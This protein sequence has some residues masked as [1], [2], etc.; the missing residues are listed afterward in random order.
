MIVVLFFLNIS[1]MD[2]LTVVAV[3]FL[4]LFCLYLYFENKKLNSIIKELRNEDKK[5]YSKNIIKEDIVKM[6]DISNNIVEEKMV[7]VCDN[8]INNGVKEDNNVI[9]VKKEKSILKDSDKEVRFDIKDYVRKDKVVNR[10]LDSSDMN[11]E[12]LQEVSRELKSNMAPQT[13]KLTDYEQEQEDNAIISYKELL[14]VNKNNNV[15]EDGTLE[16]IE[17]L[18]KFRNNLRR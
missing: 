13:I 15:V 17:E 16:F 12:Y 5:N 6:E 11:S 1:F 4:C 7:N 18:K 14:N 10:K 9:E 3:I 2:N 8:N